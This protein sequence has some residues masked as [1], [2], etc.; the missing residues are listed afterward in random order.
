MSSSIVGGKNMNKYRN[1][2]KRMLTFVLALALLAPLSAGA[3]HPSGYWP[4]HVAYND[5]V[6]TG[7]VDEILKT[8]DALL[9]FYSNYEMN[10]DIAANSYNVYYYRYINSI[11]EKRGDYAAAKDNL[12]KLLYVS[13]I[14]GI[15]DMDVA[16]SMKAR[17]I[18]THLDVF[19][20]T[21]TEEHSL[22]YGAK[23]EPHDG[24][25]YGRTL[26]TVNNHLGDADKLEDESIVSLYINLGKET[27]DQYNWLLEEVG[28]EGKALQVA[29]NYPNE[30]ITAAEITWGLHDENIR[31]TARYLEGLDFPVLL[32]VGA[33]VN[34]W[35]T[36]TT[37]ETF[38]ESYIRVAN[39]VR[40]VAPSVALEFSL[41]C[42]GGYGDEMLDY[43][44]G[45]EYVDWVGI[46]LY[47]NRYRDPATCEEGDDFGNMYFGAGDWGEPVAS[48]AEVI[49]KFGDKKPIIISEGGV[50]HF[51]TAK[52]VDLTD[53]ARDRVYTAYR[54]LTMV[55]PQ[56][57][58]IIYFD[59]NTADSLY[60]YDL[61]ENGE[62]A[63]AYEKAGEENKTFLHTL[64][65]TPQHYVSLDEFCDAVD[66][67]AISAYCYAHYSGDVYVDY[68]LD[69]ALLGRGVGV[70]HE[71]T[72]NADSLTT[73]SHTFTA[74]FSNGSN[75]NETKKYHL[76]KN[77][78]GVIDFAAEA[79]SAPAAAVSSWAKDE[80]DMAYYMGLV[81]Q[82]LLT[83]FTSKIT[84]EEFCMLI[85]SVVSKS[86]GMDNS[87]ILKH[88]GKT[89]NSGAFTD[90]KNEAALV[91][92]A[93]GILNGRGN[94]IFD[95]HSSITRQEAAAMLYNT[96][97]LL[98]TE[99]G[100]PNAFAD[101]ESIASWAKNAVSFISSV[102]DRMSGNAVMGGV[103]NNMFGPLGTYTKEQAILTM[104]RLFNA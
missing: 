43:Y 6:K 22:H 82:Y 7:N 56:I 69:G 89:V 68:Y 42:V 77:E 23:N 79:E 95:P 13:E 62:V 27:A 61:E 93:I 91:A 31:K 72:L 97:K 46:S 66:T 73:G 83:D 60:H 51:N 29:M 15:A 81:P 36:P 5:A 24:V 103:G 99:G 57:K 88:F 10:F 98:G 90:T 30:G 54:T 84:R 21:S 78:Y 44:P 18:D 59:T 34:V 14:A 17:K 38:K 39:I 12:E 94:G 11:F 58:G 47:Y 49:E 75:F 55:Y 53:Y 92:N 101:E 104:V 2:L 63:D 28:M 70:A 40:E 71:L 74:V 64:N 26:T 33:E 65:S 20:L 35:T 45:D 76:T 52:N 80:V 96:A 85:M 48:A 87:E 86:L 1:A 3:A 67:V 37:P 4:Y 50:G 19:A 16:T 25:Y 32:R 8:G 41:N 100:E 102:K 9:N